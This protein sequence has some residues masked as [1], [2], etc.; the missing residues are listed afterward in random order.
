MDSF[1]GVRVV[2]VGDVM[3]ERYG[4]DSTAVRELL[5]W[6]KRRVAHHG[7]AAAEGWPWSYASF[8]SGAPIARAA[9]LLWR[10]RAD[11]YSAFDDP[12]ATGPGTL[13]T[14]LAREQPELLEA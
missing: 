4:S 2:C 9:R 12:F 14:W 5:N 13:H 3:I 11:L 8:D 7:V 10:A 1:A 6:Y